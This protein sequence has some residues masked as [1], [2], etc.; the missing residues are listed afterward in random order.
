VIRGSFIA[1]PNAQYSASGSSTSTGD[2]QFI[3]LM[4]VDSTTSAVL[5]DAYADSEDAGKISPTTVS[6]APS[7]A[8]KSG[9]TFTL[10]LS[11][12]FDNRFGGTSLETVNA[13]EQFT[14]IQTPE[15]TGFAGMILIAGLTSL[16]RS[17]KQ[18]RN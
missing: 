5:Y 14:F 13:S 4:L 9:D 6:G 11:E 16:C 3:S 17:P 7:G 12:E 18:R 10:S 2:Y 1:G 15:P 8:L